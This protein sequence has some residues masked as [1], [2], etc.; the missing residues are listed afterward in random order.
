VDSLALSIV[1][2]LILAFDTLGST[3]SFGVGRIRRVS[4]TFN[5]L[6]DLGS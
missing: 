4:D 1:G 3:R 6:V 2:K 5:G